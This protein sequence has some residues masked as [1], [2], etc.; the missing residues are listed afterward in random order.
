VRTANALGLRQSWGL[1]GFPP[2]RDSWFVCQARLLN[3]ER[4]DLFT[5]EPARDY[6][7]PAL[8][9]TQYAN[10][11]WRKLH[12]RIRFPAAESYRLPLLEYYGRRW[13]AAHD[14]DRQVVRLQLFCYSQGLGSEDSPEDQ[15]MRELLAQ[16]VYGE[17]GGNFAEEL[18]E[19]DPY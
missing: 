17:A 4:I 19:L 9:S 8:A 1:F 3:G 15:F 6:E 7:K 5:G 18:R 2:E 14:A 10:H 16:K 11:R 12:W 13:N